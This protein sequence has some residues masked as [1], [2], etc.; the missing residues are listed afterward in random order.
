MHKLLISVAAIAMAGGLV[1]APAQAAVITQDFDFT[2]YDFYSLYDASTPPVDP[3]IG[4][5]TITFDDAV[6]AT[7]KTTG[8]VLNSLNIALDGPIGFT[9]LAGTHGMVI[10]GA[11]GVGGVS[12]VNIGTNDFWIQIRAANTTPEFTVAAYS[13]TGYPNTG[14]LTPLSQTTD[15]SSVS[16]APEPGAWALMLLGFGGAG[17]LLR[18]RRAALA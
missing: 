18:R 9:Y 10:G 16:A 15:P 2:S 6:N 14:F 7:D 5:V 13:Q 8:I 17:A 12:Q 1:A 4:S 3:M 11:S